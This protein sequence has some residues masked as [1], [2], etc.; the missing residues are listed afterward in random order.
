VRLI[1]GILGNVLIWTQTVVYPVYKPTDAARGLNPL[2]DQNLAGAAMMVEQMFLTI[3]LLGWLFYRFALQDEQRQALMDLA[4]E[5]GVELSDDRA[6]RAAAAGAGERL[7][8][9]LLGAETPEP[10]AAESSDAGAETPTR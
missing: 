3:L 5:R 4:T 10:T 9:R 1:G 8:E 6:A 2:S 7:R